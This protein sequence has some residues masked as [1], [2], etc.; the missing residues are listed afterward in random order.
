MRALVQRVTK[1]CVHATANGEEWARIGPGF[2][3]LLAASVDDTDEEARWMAGKIARLR[4][5]PDQAG[6]MNRSLL[7]SGGEVLVVSQF[8]LYGSTRRGNRPGFSRAARPEKAQPLIEATVDALRAQG[9]SVQTGRFGADMQVSLV[10]DGPVTVWIDS[11][12]DS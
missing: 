1:A 11:Q 12:E 5:L 7:D 6:L 10:N 9:L 4:I 2:L 8:T 3:V